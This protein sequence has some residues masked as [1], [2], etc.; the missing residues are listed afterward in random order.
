MRMVMDMK[1]QFSDDV[2]GAVAQKIPGADLQKPEAQA[3]E[4]GGSVAPKITL[5][6]EKFGGKVS[7]KSR[8]E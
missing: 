8:T 5:V 2:L 7:L 4:G 6:F 1:V 3:S